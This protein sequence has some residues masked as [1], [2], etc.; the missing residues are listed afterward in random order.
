MLRQIS[1]RETVRRTGLPKS[2]PPADDPA[3]DV[4]CGRL[5]GPVVMTEGGDD[6]L[7][8]DDVAVAEGVGRRD[9]LRSSRTFP[10]HGVRAENPEGAGGDRLPRPVTRMEPRESGGAGGQS[11][12]RLRSGGTSMRSSGGGSRVVPEGLAGMSSAQR[13]VRGGDDRTSRSSSSRSRRAETPLGESPQEHALA[14]HV[15]VRR[16]RRGR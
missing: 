10:G 16:S 6:V 15:E 1:G 3:V 7:G 12:P 11:V 13:A 9:A 8:V 5:A 2:S 14:A 4:A